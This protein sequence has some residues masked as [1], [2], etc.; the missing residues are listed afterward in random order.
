VQSTK[1]LLEVSNRGRDLLAKL[2]GY[3][4]VFALG[5]LKG[6]LEGSVSLLCCQHRL[7]ECPLD[8]LLER[9]RLRT[10]CLKIL[11]SH[12]RSRRTVFVTS[13]AGGGSVCGPLVQA[14]L[15]ES[16]LAVPRTFVLE[17]SE[18]GGLLP[19]SVGHLR[20]E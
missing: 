1:K 20:Q 11:S 12:Q 3:R 9:G 15:F 2:V 16:G 17:H 10:G 6:P 14:P 7:V 4:R 8:V 18:S 19:E 5:C 13:E